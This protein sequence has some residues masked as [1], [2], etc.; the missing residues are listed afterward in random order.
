MYFLLFFDLCCI[1]AVTQSVNSIDM[2]ET[3]DNSSAV[4]RFKVV[5]TL[6]HNDTFK[7][8]ALLATSLSVMSCTYMQC[9]T[10]T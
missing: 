1:A 10:P 9:I 8:V 5:S 7:C 3:V 6:D 4:L 2:E